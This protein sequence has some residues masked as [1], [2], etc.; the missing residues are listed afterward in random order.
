MKKKKLTL[1]QKITRTIVYSIF[2]VSVFTFYAILFSDII[3][4]ILYF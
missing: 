3:D 4:K 2:T 1:V